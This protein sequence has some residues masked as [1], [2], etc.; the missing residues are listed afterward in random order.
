MQ[1]RSTRGLPLMLL[2]VLGCGP[3]GAM[4]SEE[5]CEGMCEL[6]APLPGVGECIEGQCSPTFHG[7]FDKA[8]FDT[9]DAYCESIGSAC[10]ENACGGAT[11]VIHA[12]VEW[13]EDPNKEGVV[14]EGTCGDPIGWQVNSGAQCCCEQ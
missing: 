5:G 9:C 12:I 1:A 2:L 14:R 8:D 11:Y 10:A 6:Y 7:C 3:S 13:C 4:S